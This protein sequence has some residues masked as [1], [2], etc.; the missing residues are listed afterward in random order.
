MEEVRTEEKTMRRERTFH[1]VTNLRFTQEH[2]M[3]VVDGK[4]HRFAL[5]RIS[6]RLARATMKQRRVYRID[7]YGYGIHW[8]L[9]DEDLSIDGLLRT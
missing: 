8:T 9:V 7:P 1:A 3:L 5:K 2:M 6:P 4:E